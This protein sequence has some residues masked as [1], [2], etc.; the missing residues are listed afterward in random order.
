MRLF[1]T[2]LCIVAAVGC[3]DDDAEAP[4]GGSLDA[5]NDAA[6]D[7]MRDADAPAMDARISDGSDED[8]SDVSDAGDAGDAGECLEASY[9]WA[10]V[11]E[12]TI[13]PTYYGARRLTLADFC[14]RYDCPAD[15]NAA[16]AISREC[17][18][19]EDDAGPG[20]CWTATTEC[21]ANLLTTFSGNSHGFLYYD[22][23]TGELLGGAYQF[24]DESVTCVPS[25]NIAGE[26]PP[27]CCPDSDAG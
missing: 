24:T 16:L 1:L 4:D 22:P 25:E 9:I 18:D 19:D 6:T 23:A 2:T 7:G 3:G 13:E 20:L 27:I 11:T 17:D 15:W 26:A 5:G 21:G 8:A 10:Q 12:C 14:D